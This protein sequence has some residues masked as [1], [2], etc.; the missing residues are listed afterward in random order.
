MFWA[1]S[2]G[3]DQV[4]AVMKRFHGTHGDWLEPAALLQRLAK[5]GGTFG[6]WR[7]G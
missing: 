4:Y 2:L 7:A 6:A 5:E 1:D 3:L